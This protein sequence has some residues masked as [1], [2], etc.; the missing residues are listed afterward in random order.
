MFKAIIF[1]FDGTLAD[2]WEVMMLAF[3]RMAG[4]Y[5]FPLPG[6]EQL[7]ELKNLPIKDRF[8]KMG[9]PLA[10]MPEVIR[11]IKKTFVEQQD[12]L[13]P[14]P[15]MRETFLL[16]AERGFDLYILS[17]NTRE[18][19]GNF[20]KAHAMAVPAG[21]NPSQGLLGK[22]RTILKLLQKQGL[23]R[24]EVLYVGDELRDIEACRAAGIKIMV[25]TWGYDGQALLEKGQP[26]Y[27]AHTPQEILEI[28]G[29]G[30][31]G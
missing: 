6:W 22:H 11:N 26:D 9:L 15:G 27:I 30:Q 28:V 14:F 18:V 17:T 20:L 1:D 10:R 29:E 2:S 16:L 5:D 13:R 8:K 12:T 19:I 3:R 21:I 31:P 4:K 23:S 24:E 25:V 7:V